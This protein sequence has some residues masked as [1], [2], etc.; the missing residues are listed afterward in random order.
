MKK[1]IFLPSIMALTLMASGCGSKGHNLGGQNA[2]EFGEERTGPQTT[3]T[4]NDM[5]NRLGYVR[6]KQDEMNMD[7]EN[8][9]MVTID[10]KKMADTITRMLLRHGDFEEA[11]TLVT[12]EEVLISYS[13]PEDMDREKAASIAKKTA[14][15]VMP[16]YFH[17]YVSD[18]PT[19]FRQIQSLKNSTTTDREY[20]NTLESII[21][22]MK[23]SPQG[24]DWKG[25]DG[26]NM[27]IN[28]QTD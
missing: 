2:D 16:G 6:Y 26:E 15:S 5:T 7:Q 9:Q 25:A 8:Q 3:E 17:I 14:M 11:A 24:D 13:K 21:S 20:D 18:D 28:H 4:E 1:R 19:S 10:R 22:D 12:D 23:N 27:N